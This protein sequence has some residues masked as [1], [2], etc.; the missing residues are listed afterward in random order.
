MIIVIHQMTG[1]SV[2]LNPSR[3]Q[4]SARN[5]AVGSL[6]DTQKSFE[7]PLS[8]LLSESD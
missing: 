2:I 1:A 7:V 3:A 4:N 5:T 6:V 8:V